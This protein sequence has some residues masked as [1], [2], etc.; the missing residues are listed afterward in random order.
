MPGQWHLFPP[1]LPCCS[2]HL[3]FLHF[4]PPFFSV[5]PSFTSG[6]VFFLSLP[7]TFPLLLLPRSSS[8]LSLHSSLHPSHY[9]IPFLPNL[10]PSTLPLQTI[11]YST[12]L[13]ELDIQD[14]R[15]LEVSTSTTEGCHYSNPSMQDLVIE[16]IYAGIMQAKLDQRNE[17][18]R[19][20]RCKYM[21]MY[22]HYMAIRSGGLDLEG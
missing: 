12:L 3:S 18:V 22:I 10:F 2:H 8:F 11:P 20:C 6:L 19:H 21:S 5:L 15:I 9:C 17:Q 7:I 14:L 13:R 4:L 16:A 1:F